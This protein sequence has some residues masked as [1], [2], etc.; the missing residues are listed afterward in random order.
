VLPVTWVERAISH[1][2]QMGGLYILREMERSG[3]KLLA[4]VLA[5]ITT[6]GVQVC[7]MYFIFCFVDNSTIECKNFHTNVHFRR[8]CK[9]A[10]IDR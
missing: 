9:I 1:R 7:F 10:K 6:T 5:D 8:F 2:R 3:K 4:N